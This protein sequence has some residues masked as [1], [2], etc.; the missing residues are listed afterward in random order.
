[1]KDICTYKLYASEHMG[2][3]CF[4]DILRKVRFSGYKFIDG[5][6]KDI[7]DLRN[8]DLKELVKSYGSIRKK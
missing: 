4:I 1:M 8:T 3:R 6:D 7:E 2:N 5:Q